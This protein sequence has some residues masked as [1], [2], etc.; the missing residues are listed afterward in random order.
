MSNFTQIKSLHHNI[1]SYQIHAHSYHV[2]S[3][4]GQ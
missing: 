1:H 2:M 3:I 4:S